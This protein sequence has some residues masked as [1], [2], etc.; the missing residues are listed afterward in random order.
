MGSEFNINFFFALS[1]EQQFVNFYFLD[2]L[3][4]PNL[5]FLF[6]LKIHD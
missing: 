6:Q 3:Q 5:T 1:F 4:F 2:I